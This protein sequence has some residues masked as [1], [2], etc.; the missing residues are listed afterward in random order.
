MKKGHY[1]VLTAPLDIPEKEFRMAATR[2]R[3][4]KKKSAAIAYHDELKI[5]SHQYEI[6]CVHKR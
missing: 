1:I 5:G 2:S 4:F 3:N 6:L